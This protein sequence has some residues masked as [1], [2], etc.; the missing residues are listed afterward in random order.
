MKNNS[1]DTVGEWYAANITNSQTR[2]VL[3]VMTLWDSYQLRAYGRK[4]VAPLIDNNGRG[5]AP[6]G[7]ANVVPDRSPATPGNSTMIAYESSGHSPADTKRR[8]ARGAQ[9]R[10]VEPGQ[11]SR[12]PDFPTSRARSATCSARPALMPA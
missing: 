4:D 12:Q 8:H 10:P 3:G 5:N 9:D 6:W 7:L 11:V 2:N 1:G